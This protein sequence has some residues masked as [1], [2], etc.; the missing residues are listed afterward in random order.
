M[1]RISAE[2]LGSAERIC[3]YKDDI[4]QM[5]ALKC[6]AGRLLRLRSGTLLTSLLDRL[7]PSLTH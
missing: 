1:D 2:T 3:L 4:R 7:L 5:V 6:L